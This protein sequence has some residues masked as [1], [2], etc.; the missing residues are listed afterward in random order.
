[1]V[2]AVAADQGNYRH[3][4]GGNPGGQAMLKDGSKK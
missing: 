1:M 4:G 2:I 3:P